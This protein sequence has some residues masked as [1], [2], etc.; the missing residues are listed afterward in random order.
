MALILKISIH[1]VSRKWHSMHDKNIEDENQRA[2]S[3]NGNYP[4]YK[5]NKYGSPL[6]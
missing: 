6:I 2:T 4:H 1:I 5:D 3:G